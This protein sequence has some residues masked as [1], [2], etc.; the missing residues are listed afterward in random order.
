MVNFAVTSYVHGPSSQ[1]ARL[2]LAKL[3]G[4]PLL[5][6]Q[7]QHTIHSFSSQTLSTSLYPQIP[8]MSME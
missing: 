6:T 5:K 3:L 7:D 4:A 1:M 2:E 8:C